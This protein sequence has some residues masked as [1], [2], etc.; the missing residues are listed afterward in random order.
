MQKYEY[1]LV[2]IAPLIKNHLY[3]IILRPKDDHPCLSFYAG[4]H[5]EI[6][7]PNGAFCLFSIANAP[8]QDQLLICYSHDP[9]EWEALMA[10]KQ[11]KAKMLDQSEI[12][13][14]FRGPIG[15]CVYSRFPSDKP[16]ILVAA[17]SA[18]IAPIRAFVEQIIASNDQRTWHIFWGA[19]EEK[20]FFMHDLFK[21]WEA[22]CLNL[23]YTPV[24]S[25]RQDGLSE[26]YEQGL[27]HQAVIRHYNNMSDFFVYLTGPSAMIYSSKALYS[28]HGLPQESLMADLLDQEQTV[29]AH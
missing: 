14:V 28:Q 23:K 2:D 4:Q 20:H 19:E 3:Q 5:V 1:I 21:K 26:V 13:I 29:Q 22:S 9:E 16:I 15:Q 24:I 17:G 18:S 12:P 25:E 6:K 11:Q 27:V 8:R 7:M 10:L